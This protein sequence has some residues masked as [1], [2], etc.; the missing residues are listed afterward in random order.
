MKKLISLLTFLLLSE[1]QFLGA[2]TIDTLYVAGPDSVAV[3]NDTNIYSFAE[4]MPRYLGGGTA[5]SDYL[6]Q[7]IKYPSVEK[8]A[9]KQGTVYVQFVV[10]KDG[11]VSNVK[12]MKGVPDAPGLGRE[13]I[14]VVS[15]SPDWNPALMNGKPV[16]CRMTIPIKF[17]L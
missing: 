8:K 15:E 2:Q 14:R 13:A 11:R 10:E 16:R 1:V 9:G 6:A 7:N 17:A 12:L 4:V 5:F 3:A